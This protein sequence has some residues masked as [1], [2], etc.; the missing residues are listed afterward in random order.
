MAD[1]MENVRNF[2]EPERVAIIGASHH[3]GSVGNIIAKNMRD[4]K[5]SLFFINPNIPE[6]FGRKCLASVLDVKEKIDL[7]VIVVK[8]DIV[9]KVLK[10]CGRKGIHSV[11]IITAGFSEVGN[12]KGENEILSIAK[13]FKIR[14]IGPNCFG[15]VNPYLHLNSTFAL[16]NIREGGIAFISQSGALGAAIIDIAATENFGFSRMAFLGNECDIDFNEILGYVDSDKDTKTILLYIESLKKGGE[17]LKIAQ[18]CTKPIV[19]VKAGT[20]SAGTMAALTH[21]GSLSGNAEIYKAAFR[22]S[23]VIL[24]DSLTQG[25]DIVRFLSSYGRKKIKNAVIVSNAGGAAV[26]TADYC[27]KE[28]LNIPALSKSLTQKLN[29]ILPQEWSHNNPIDMIGDATAERYEKVFS[30]LA[31]E[32]FF[33]VL[34]CVLTPQSMT[35]PM[36][37]AMKLKEFAEKTGKIAVACFI[38]GRRVE[39]AVRYLKGNNI[40]CFGEPKK[41]AELLSALK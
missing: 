24:A 2:F 17:F 3:E 18:K 33:D 9:L 31:E 15:T 11:I 35:Q 6:L 29:K 1:K 41:C 12:K 36:E 22:Q 10:E 5:G 20:S 28:G 4:F 27:E 13:K 40:F 34:I 37:T 30:L 14:I 16:N 7:A 26:L 21:T 39:K 19:A 25:I 32:N 38:G 8:P 23:N